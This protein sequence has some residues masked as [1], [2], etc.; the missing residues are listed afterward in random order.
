MTNSM[1]MTNSLA[2]G[3]ASKIDQTSSLG[4]NFMKLLG[5]AGGNRNL[6]KTKQAITLSPGTFGEKNS[7]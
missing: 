2:M 3:S 7:R 4:Q 5:K 1:A 6:N